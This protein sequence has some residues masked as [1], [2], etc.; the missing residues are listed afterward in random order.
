MTTVAIG[1][2][3]EDGI[4]TVAGT[5]DTASTSVNLP[6][7]RS[8]RA[9]FRF[10]ALPI[11][12]A[13]TDFQRTKNLYGSFTLTVGGGSSEDGTLRFYVVD[14]AAPAAFS[15]TNLPGGPDEILVSTVA[16]SSASVSQ[17]ATL[18]LG[19]MTRIYRRQGWS[20]R[21][22][23]TAEW[24]APTTHF[25]MTLTGSSFGAPTLEAGDA[26]P[27]HTGMVGERWLGSR[28]VQDHKTGEFI[29][30]DDAVVDPLTR[31][32]VAPENADPPEERRRHRTS[33]RLPRRRA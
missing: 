10:Q 28:I 31:A 14:A 30:E 17:T 15:D 6:N 25:E 23:F 24:E 19:A 13:G 26:R 8:R 11:L 16:V 21:F 5:F 3:I 29:R 33:R 27:E 20:G 22:A 4:R 1:N 32:L 12:L 9:G 18:D 7:D 2:T